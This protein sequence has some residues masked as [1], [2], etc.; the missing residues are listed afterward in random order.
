M[1]NRIRLWLRALFRP[2]A[3]GIYGVI[4]YGVA[5]RTGE[6]GIRRALGAEEGEVMGMV[7]KQGLGLTGMGLVLGLAGAVGGVGEAGEGPTRRS[8]FPGGPRLAAQSNRR[9][10]GAWG[11]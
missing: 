1:M 6:I 8:R 9:A 2:A 3:I 7:L 11:R 5:L 4:S 10:S